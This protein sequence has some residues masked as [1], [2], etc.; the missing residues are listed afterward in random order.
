MLERLSWKRLVLELV[1]VC[2][3]ALI[4]GLRFGYLPWLLM[5]ALLALMI[6]HARNLMRLSHWVWV[7]RKMTPP[8]GRGSWE[9]VFYGLNQ[10]QSRNRRRRRELRQL[11]K[12]FRSGAESLPDA[13]VLATDDGIIFWCN[14][15]AQQILGLRWPE[16]YGQNILNLLRYPEFARYLRERDFSR[17]L[18]LVISHSR[19]IEFRIMPYSEGQWL[20][21]ARD[22]TQMHNL[23]GARRN[24]FANVSHELRTP[25]TVLQGYLEVL[26]DGEMPPALRE[27]ALSTMQEQSRRMDT[28]VKQL[29][30]LSRI[31]AAPSFELQDKIDV[32][33]MLSMLQREAETLSGGRHQIHFHTDPHLRVLGNDEQLR[34]AISNLVYN[35]VN[36][37]PQGT[38]IDVSW[39][40]TPQGGARFTVKDN[41]PGIAP[42]HIPRLTER[43]YRV[44]K[45]RSRQTGGSGL[46]LAIVKHALSHHNA[47]LD[48]TSVAH[49]ETV[50]SFTLAPGRIVPQPQNSRV[51][52]AR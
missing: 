18:T 32:P 35:A 9:S 10:M 42:E 3:P 14:G 27:K 41:G 11:I 25:L 30:T 19:H 47:R 26:Q 17:P 51:T 48:I 6:W 50:F 22:V 38:R 46:G 34:S 29:L 28:L 7:D 13:L 40:R 39:L 4:V 37:T 2:L 8:T 5:L 1:L 43:F 15:L 20:I 24:F 12:R 31:E 33:V 23:E 49:Q 44:D 36:H 16:D 21:V 45:A 52:S